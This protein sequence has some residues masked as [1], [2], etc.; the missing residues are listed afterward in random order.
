MSFPFNHYIR[1]HLLSVTMACMCKMRT[2][3]SVLC[4]LLS[5]RHAA[6]APLVGAAE[7]TRVIKEGSWR[8]AMYTVSSGSTHARKYF[9]VVISK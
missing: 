9:E 5:S 6:G 1:A 7:S 3:S 4:V 8:L 2:Y